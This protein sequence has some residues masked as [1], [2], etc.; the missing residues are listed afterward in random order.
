MKLM[1]LLKG[2]NTRSIKGDLAAEISGISYDSRK[3]GPGDMFVCIPG[4]KDDG[5]KYVKQARERGVVVF[6][7]SR[8][9]EA[10]AAQAV[11]VVDEP[12]LEMG[13]LASRLAGEP[14]RK[15]QL[16][17]I[18]GTN[19]KTTVSYLVESISA[20]E[21]MD[22]GVI[23]T[24]NYRWKG[25]EISSSNTTPE[26]VEV[27][28]FLDQM[29]KAGVRRAAMEVSSHALDQKRVAGICFKAGIFTNLTPEHLD[30]HENM[31][32]YFLAKA[33]LFTEALAGK[34]LAEKINFAPLSV[35]NLDDAFGEKLLALAAGKKVG[36]S[37]A[38]KSALYRGQIVHYGWDGIRIKMTVPGGE[39]E[40]QSPMLGKINA[41]NILA[42]S[43]CLIELGTAR[44][45]IAQGVAALKQVPGRMERVPNS[46]GLLVLVD[47]AH[48]PDAL[49]NLV[50]IAK[51]MEIK[52]LVLVF[53]C[54]GDRDRKK[55]PEMGKIAAANA[56]LVVVTSDNPR[57]EHPGKII[58]EIEAGIKP[59]GFSKAQK[60]GPDS[61]GYII[62][63]DRKAAI[64]MALA[65]AREGDC[66]LIAGKG[67]EDYQ[68]L[69]EKKIHFDDR[70]EVR[71]ALG[72][73]G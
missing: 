3:A 5:H 19:G 17:G 73:K 33:R 22:C 25:Q 1:E 55:R 52:R 12:R 48:T 44:E 11:V 14:S 53:G 67:H 32:A 59:T 60:P 50:R 69:G 13:K 24:I 26:S 40:L 56:E 31:E 57:T 47:Y 39:L 71:R 21:G 66:V 72:A 7:A 30:Y 49:E 37:L 63:P 16:L 9:V 64:Q 27:I 29:L 41:Y 45:K 20:A 51:E 46:R 58:A 62:E 43:A 15:L 2:I 68:I 35:I 38:K 6:L 23:G 28:G 4:T 70:E 61:K 34:W 65:S 8:E 42:A 54:G 36:Y 10:E 18:T